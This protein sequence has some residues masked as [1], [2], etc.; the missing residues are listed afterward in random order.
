MPLYHREIGI[1]KA[2]LAT[3]AGKNVRLTYT[4]HAM[5]EA[6]RDRYGIINKPPFVATLDPEKIFEVEAHI[7]NSGAWFVTKIA[8][9]MEYDNRRDLIVVLIPAGQPGVLKV[10]TLWTNLRTDK[11]VTLQ[12]EKYERIT[13]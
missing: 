12:K 1:P 4:Q 8:M 9:R 11:H 6:L 3:I 10:K 13:V 7:E 5:A 2:A